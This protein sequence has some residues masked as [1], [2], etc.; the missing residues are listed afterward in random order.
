MTDKTKASHQVSQPSR[1]AD[2]A[3]FQTSCR[4]GFVVGLALATVVRDAVQKSAERA[5]GMDTLSAAQQD[6]AILKRLR[7]FFWVCAGYMV[8][9]KCAVVGIC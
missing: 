9:G 8:L 3:I 7:A 2:Q 6:E 1:R 4:L 5:F